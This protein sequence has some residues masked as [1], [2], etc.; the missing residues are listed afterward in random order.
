MNIGWYYQAPS[1]NL[2]PDQLRCETF[3]LGYEAHGVGD[4]ALAGE[5]HLSAGLHIADSLRR[6]NPDQVQR[7][8]LSRSPKCGRHP[9]RTERYSHWMALGSGFRGLPERGGHLEQTNPP[10]FRDWWT[11]TDDRLLDFVIPAKGN[12]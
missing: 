8:F 11:L 3:A 12:Q 6:Y 4:L 10:A 1:G 2:V 7:D 5:V 9:C